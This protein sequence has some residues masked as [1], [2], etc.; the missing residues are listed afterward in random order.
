[1]LHQIMSKTPVE[2]IVIHKHLPPTSA[3]ENFTESVLKGLRSLDYSGRDQIVQNVLS[4]AL[5]F[6]IIWIIM[7][8]CCVPRWSKGCGTIIGAL[9]RA[10]CQTSHSHRNRR[11]HSEREREMVRLNQQ[12]EA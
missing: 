1:M 8:P 11:C 12:E 9:C 3:W 10:C 4:L 2:N 6:V 5:I 7:L